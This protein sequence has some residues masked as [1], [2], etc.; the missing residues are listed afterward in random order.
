MQG[1]LTFFNINSVK[2]ILIA[3]VGMLFL[4]ACDKPFAS[5]YEGIWAGIIEESGNVIMYEY[6]IEESEGNAFVISVIRRYY[7]VTRSSDKVERAVWTSSEPKLFPATYEDG[8]L[9]TPFGLLEYNIKDFNLRYKNH[10]FVRKAKNV[11][12]KFK[13]QAKIA[14]KRKYPRAVAYD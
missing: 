1:Y 9:K 13:E 11:E 3:L 8:L 7:N 14:L 4:T 5:N 2:A 10:L 12:A 6:H